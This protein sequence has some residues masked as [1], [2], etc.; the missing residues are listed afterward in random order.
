MKECLSVYIHIP[1]CIRKCPYCNFYS[2][3]YHLDKGLWDRYEQAVLR[4]LDE[5]VKRYALKERRVKTLY[6]GGGTPSAIQADG[7]SS[8]LERLHRKLDFS[9]LEEATVE[10]NPADVDVGALRQYRDA[11]IT[12]VSLGVQSFDEDK[13]A[14][15]GRRHSLKD[16]I[17]AVELCKGIFSD[18]VSIDLI[19]GVPGEELSVW[20]A[21]VSQAVSMEIGHISLYSLTIEPGTV[22]YERYAGVEND[23][24]SARMYVL[25][26]EILSN[27]GIF[28]YEIS[29]F[30]FPGKES[31]HNL[32]YWLGGEFIG[33]GPSASSFLDGARFSVR[34]DLS[35]FLNS[36]VEYETDYLAE[37]RRYR[38]HMVLRM[39]TRYGVDKNSLPLD[40][41]DKIVSFMEMGWIEDA[42]DRYVL[43]LEGRLFSDEIASELI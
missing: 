12:R 18:S 7:I 24:V 9:G 35:A 36:D 16:G 17:R 8:L 3:E 43:T 6:I 15:L 30:S 4:Q 39:R 25:A 22:F 33:L 5:L 34:T 13:L 26:D 19:F 27:N 42:G 23:E 29:N 21:D 38:E 32:V 14:L 37:D 28:W 11:G 10:L 2:L 31:R 20:E 40:W 1:F 41:V